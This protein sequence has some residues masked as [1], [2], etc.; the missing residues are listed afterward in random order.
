MPNVQHHSLYD[1]RQFRPALYAL[2]LL[3]MTGFAF[4]A[5]SPA[6]WVLGTGAVLLHFWLV[7]TGRFHPLPR[8][9]ANAVTILGVAALA[10][11]LQETEGTPLLT[12]GHFLVLLQMVKLYEQRANR[13][14]AQLLILSLLLMVAAAIS[15]ASLLFGLM[16]VAYLFLSLY[17]C[18]LFH[19]KTEAD[20]ARQVIGPSEVD[21]HPT[22]IRQDQNR[23]D[24]SM[25]RLIALISSFAI[26]T[27]VLTFLLF[28]RGPGA[29]LFGQNQYKVTQSLTGFSDTVGFQNVA[30]ISQN[31]RQVATVK[32]DRLGMPYQGVLLLRGV[33]LDRYTGGAKGSG[34]DPYVWKRTIDNSGP[35]I[36]IQRRN[37]RDFGVGGVIHQEV[38]LDP[39]GTPALFAV[40]GIARFSSPDERPYRYSEQDGV[41]QAADPLQERIRYEVWS[42]DQISG[43]RETADQIAGIGERDPGTRDNRYFS[44]I[45]SIIDPKIRQIAMQEEVSGSDEEGPLA[46]RRDQDE[47]VTNL[48]T[49]IAKNIERYLKNNFTYTLDLTDAARIGNTD[50][51][52]AFLTDFKRGHC[53]YFAGAMALLCQSLGIRAR[54]VVGFKCDEYNA[55]G[56]YY[57]VR[58]SHAHAW[59]EVL[60]PDNVWE[61]FDP[62]TGNEDVSVRMDTVWQRIRA[63][64]NYLE[65]QWES[66]VITDDQSR[67]NELLTSS[68][69]QVRGAAE[70]SQQA[71]KDA[72]NWQG[73][74]FVSLNILNALVTLMV[75]ALVGSVGWF[76]WEKSRLRR[77]ARRIGLDTLPLEEQLKLARQLRFYDELVRLLERHGIIR[78][79]HLTPLEFSSSLAY[80]PTEAFDSIRH[81]TDIFYRV[82]FGRAELSPEQQRHLV[83]SIV[84]VENSLGRSLA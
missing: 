67:R 16:L 21:Q 27:A 38:S 46:E 12:I 61:T 77:R 65:F 23:F 42:R 18:L 7:Q 9:V 24:Q 13:D 26:T 37:P 33:T 81:L 78:P 83:H 5:E 6:V 76:L 71:V 11:V 29:G 73:K 48:D 10:I 3:G 79:P 34:D 31:T 62:T 20:H 45:T 63:I 47:F 35:P 54:V 14:Y 39:T 51:L 66:A 56:D 82:R 55:I 1:V 40:G 25:R 2:V 75:L 59:V 19:L 68:F 36:T 41:L 74:V 28:P 50:P 80:L 60:G 64:F 58:Q 43:S 57:T 15:T 84:S 70:Q 72:W 8:I 17:C 30:R 52:V 4:A 32:V 53:E 44:S 49:T 69:R 22:T